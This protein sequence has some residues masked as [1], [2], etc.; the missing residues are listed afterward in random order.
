MTSEMIEIL[1][2]CRLRMLI[3]E[4]ATDADYRYQWDRRDWELQVDVGPAY[5]SR[6]WFNVNDDRSRQRYCR[7]IKRLVNAG[8]VDAFDLF[9]D[10]RTTHIAL[11]EAGIAAVESL[12]R[13]PG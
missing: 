12:G 1:I 11:T 10:G 5:N 13:E 9:D 2:E 8:L 4:D 3:L 6:E 7:A